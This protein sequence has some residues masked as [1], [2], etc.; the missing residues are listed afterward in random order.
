MHG[1]PLIPLRSEGGAP[2]AFTRGNTL[3]LLHE[4]RHALQRLLDTGAETTIDLGALPMGPGDAAELA[5]TLG[6]GELSAQLE[7]IGPS[8]IR[9]TAFPG[10]WWVTHRN[11]DD[12]IIAQFLEVTFM[13]SILRSQMEDV[14]HGL[15][16]LTSKLSQAVPQGADS[17]PDG[18]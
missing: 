5:A 8:T 16:A 1:R 15:E 9:E 3:P 18:G 7:A 2:D 14:K 11:Q 10:I 4:L 17:R 12:Q 13:P 6:E